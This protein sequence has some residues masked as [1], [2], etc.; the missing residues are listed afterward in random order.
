MPQQH[1]SKLCGQKVYV[2]V[3]RFVIRLVVASVR[4]FVSAM[5]PQRLVK[6]TLSA[7]R[8]AL[9]TPVEQSRPCQV[10]AIELIEYEAYEKGFPTSLVMPDLTRF[11]VK[12]QIINCLQ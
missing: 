7:T 8:S 12:R 5:F 11:S 9:K 4:T 1:G 3:T 2:N 6:N 10:V